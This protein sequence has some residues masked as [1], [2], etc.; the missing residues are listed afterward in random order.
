MIEVVTGQRLRTGDQ[1][2]LHYRGKNKPFRQGTV[3]GLYD[4][5]FNVHFGRY[6]ESFL[7]VDLLIGE[8]TIVQIGK[9]SACRAS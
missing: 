5:F 3:A 4:R 9:R 8:I 1:I 2:R 7:W 6:Q